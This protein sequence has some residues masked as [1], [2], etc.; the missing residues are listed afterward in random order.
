MG[1]GGGGLVSNVVDAVVLLVQLA[2]GVDHRGLITFSGEAIFLKVPFLLAVPALSVWVTERRR[3][4]VVT[5]VVTVVT[6]VVAIVV[7]AI[8]YAKANCGELGELIIG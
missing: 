5:L 1:C 6:V 2:I 4:A 3:T 8:V 7:I